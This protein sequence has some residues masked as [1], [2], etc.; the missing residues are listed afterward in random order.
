ME[1]DA[2]KSKR[3]VALCRRLGHLWTDRKEVVLDDVVTEEKLL[4]CGRT[5]F[6]KIFGNPTINFQAFQTIMRKAWKL[7]KVICKYLE[8]DLFSFKFKLIE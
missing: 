1:K 8:P 7:E 4:D 2:E 5:V 3:M 6:G